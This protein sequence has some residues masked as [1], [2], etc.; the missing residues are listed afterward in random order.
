VGRNAAGIPICTSP[1]R[2]RLRPIDVPL[3]QA[4]TTRLCAAAGWQSQIPLTQ[5]LAD[6]LQSWH[7]RVGWQG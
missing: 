1:S 4:D 6:L 7:E 3:L 5:T 2:S